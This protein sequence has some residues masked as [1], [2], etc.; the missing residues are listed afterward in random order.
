[1]TRALVRATD[2][3]KA[4]L[5]QYRDLFLT[6]IP[7]FGDFRATGKAYAVGERAYKDEFAGI[8]REQLRP[9]LFADVSKQEAADEVRTVTHRLLTR[10]LETIRQPQ[11]LIGWRSIA[12]LPK[13]DAAERVVFARCFKELLFGAGESPE[14][15]ERFVTG[16]WP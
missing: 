7:D 9:E 10:R 13:M 16:V 12:F 11:N 5:E 2:L 15:L 8:C 4:G 14:R 3:D 6:R 1:M